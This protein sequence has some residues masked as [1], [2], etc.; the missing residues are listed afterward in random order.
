MRLVANIA[1]N[2]G[3][4]DVVNVGNNDIGGSGARDSAPDKMHPWS[5]QEARFQ[6]TL[7]QLSSSMLMLLLL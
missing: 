7:S 5:R 1:N 2:V 3:N 4:I 6:S